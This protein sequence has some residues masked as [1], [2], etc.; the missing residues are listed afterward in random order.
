M[1]T[2][3]DGTYHCSSKLVVLTGNSAL[4]LQPRGYF[5]LR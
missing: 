4:S 5:P 2:L 3:L 1:G